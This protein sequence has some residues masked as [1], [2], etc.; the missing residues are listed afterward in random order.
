[1]FD[2]VRYSEGPNRSSY[3]VDSIE[4]R[5]NTDR[6]EGP[7]L[8]YKP[9]HKGGYFPVPPTDTLHDLRADMAHDAGGGRH[10]RRGVP[11]RGRHR[12]PVRAVDEVQQPQEDG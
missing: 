10:P 3:M 7:N 12:R 6:E 9:P 1:M 5:W 8:G 2:E 11:P 4:G